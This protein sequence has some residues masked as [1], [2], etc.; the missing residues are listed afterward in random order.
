[1]ALT[2]SRSR[3]TAGAPVNGAS[4]TDDAA[5]INTTTNRSPYVPN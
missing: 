2:K 4:V 5:A 3:V 1:M